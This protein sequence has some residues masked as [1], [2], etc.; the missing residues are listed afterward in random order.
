VIWHGYSTVGRYDGVLKA[1]NF[2]EH[3]VLDKLEAELA[4]PTP[5]A[6]DG[7]VTMEEVITEQP[8]TCELSL[9]LYFTFGDTSVILC[10]TRGGIDLHCYKC[11]SSLFFSTWGFNHSILG[12]SWAKACE[13]L[14]MV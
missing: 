1:N 7:T 14:R 3:Y 5:L 13:E 11:F 2:L 4:M 9:Y 12:I 10:Q 8:S 6:S